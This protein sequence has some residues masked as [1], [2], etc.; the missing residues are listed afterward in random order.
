MNAKS[1]R[2]T[3]YVLLVVVAI[4]LLVWGSDRITL[5][6]ERTIYTVKCEQGVWDGTRCTGRLVA[7]ER[8]AF[9]ASPRRNEVIYWIRN[10]N[11]PSG[12]Y[13][14]CAVKDRNNWSCNVQVGQL[15]SIAYELTDGRPTRSDGGLTLP[16][17]DVPKWK[18][19]LIDI[20]LGGLFSEAN[21]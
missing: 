6:G 8:F 14:D 3:L 20:G 11:A 13:S 7:G 21:R 15:P 17:H 4:T 16:F 2:R 5:Q 9:R 1:L 19:W 10:S 18:W 12:K